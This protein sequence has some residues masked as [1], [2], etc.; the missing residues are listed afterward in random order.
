MAH[1]LRQFGYKIGCQAEAAVLFNDWIKR[2]FKNFEKYCDTSDAF[3][4]IPFS[5]DYT[6]QA[7]DEVF[8]DSKFIL[9]VRDSADQWYHSLTKFHSKVVGAAAVPPTADELRKFKGGWLLKE[10]KVVYGV[11]DD[12]LYDQTIYKQH[13]D[14]HNQ[15]V[16]DYFRYRPDD[17]LVINLNSPDAMEKICDFLHIKYIGQKIPHVNKGVST[18]PR[19]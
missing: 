17:L 7:V 8:P 11:E 14:N 15:R 10:E 2:D 3:Q 5:L 6:F 1:I 13:Y 18:L 16:I 12:Q 9:T 4:D 19:A